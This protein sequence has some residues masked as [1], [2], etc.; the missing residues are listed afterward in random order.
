VTAAALA[1]AV[2]LAG[3]GCG[4]GCG[5]GSGA[6]GAA[7]DLAPAK[8][9][10]APNGTVVNLS[11]KQDRV[12]T[13]KVDAIAALVPEEIG[14]RGTLKVVDS[15]G[16]TP[17][18]D[19]YAD[20]DKTIIGVEPDIASPIGDVLGLKVEFNPVSWENIFVGLDSGKYDAGLSNITVTEAGPRWSA[21]TRAAA[22]TSSA[23][24]R[25]PPTRTTAWSRR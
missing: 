6:T 9:S 8:G 20:D 24:S 7:A 1:S 13:A 3:C 11:A 17:P 25:R 4:C 19:F 5:C 18:L 22:R 12:T 16:T 15:I 21:P 10:T 2:T 23:R 14:K